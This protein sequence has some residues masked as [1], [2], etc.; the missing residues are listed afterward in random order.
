[1]KS[2]KNIMLVEDNEPD[3]FLFEEAVSQIKNVVV[4]HIAQNGEEALEF[5]NN[6]HELPDIIF[7]DISMPRLNGMECLAAI[8]G[9]PKL[10]DIPVV[11]LT[12]SLVERTRAHQAGAQAYLLKPATIDMLTQKLRTVIELD[13]IANKTTGTGKFYED[14]IY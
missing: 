8:T 11:I 12:G 10:K 7:M 3:R 2:Y 14:L 9:N 1:M 5:L 4:Q 6:F 13:Y